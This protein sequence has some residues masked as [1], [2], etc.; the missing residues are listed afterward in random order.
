MHGNIRHS[1]QG[2]DRT[3]AKQIGT[4]AGLWRKSL[5]GKGQLNYI[6][7]KLY[8]AK[9]QK[10]Y[11]KMYFCPLEENGSLTTVDFDKV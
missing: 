8:Y 10:N 5:L 6:M 11:F 9:I 2:G 4:T 1:N 3:S 7:Y